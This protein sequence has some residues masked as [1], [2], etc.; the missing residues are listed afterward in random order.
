ML[1]VVGGLVGVQTGGL[2]LPGLIVCSSG[3]PDKIAA[4]VDTQLD[5]QKSQSGTMRAME[6]VATADVATNS[7]QAAAAS[8][9]QETGAK[10][11]VLCKAI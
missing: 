1:V 2:G 4:A 5:H 10:Q 3:I 6:Q 9:F 11:Y 7:T 8:S